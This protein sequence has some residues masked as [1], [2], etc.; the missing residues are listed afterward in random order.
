MRF[1]DETK[2][3]SITCLLDRGEMLD[4]KTETYYRKYID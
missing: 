2:T 1:Y 3:L 4:S